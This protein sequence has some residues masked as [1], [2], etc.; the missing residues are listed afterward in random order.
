MMSQSA[1]TRP[2]VP[3]G[4][5]VE[6]GKGLKIC[7]QLEAT[8]PSAVI[9]V[10]QVMTR[11]TSANSQNKPKVDTEGL[12]F[13]GEI[14]SSLLCW[15]LVTMW[16]YADPMNNTISV[17][18]GF[19]MFIFV[20][21]FVLS[22]IIFVVLHTGAD[23]KFT[24]LSCF[25]NA[26]FGMSY[27][28]AWAALYLTAGGLTASFA[29]NDKTQVLRAATAFAFILAILHAFHALVHFRRKFGKFPCSYVGCCHIECNINVNRNDD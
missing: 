19:A 29:V 2:K 20:A 9:Q 18:L 24:R 10:S 6:S 4:A 12:L 21:S 17:Q 5:G 22:I 11:S 16:L 3:L 27:N 23:Y 15:M 26:V 7:N 1:E 14:V 25:R 13:L 28:A 8:S